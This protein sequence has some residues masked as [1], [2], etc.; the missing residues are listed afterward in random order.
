[1]LPAVDNAA[2]Y[3]ATTTF[4]V[5]DL[6]LGRLTAAD[7]V[8]DLA[9]TIPDTS[10]TTYSA[11]LIAGGSITSV[12]GGG[13]G[14]FSA[15]NETLG[16]I[17]DIYASAGLVLRDFNND[18]KEDAVMGD[19]AAG[20]SSWWNGSG[21]AGLQAQYALTSA[22]AGLFG[23][24]SPVTRGAVTGSV[25]TLGIAA[26][27]VN[28]DGAADFMVAGGFVSWGPTSGLGQWQGNNG[29]AFT[30]VT[31]TMPGTIPRYRYV[32]TFDGDFDVPLDV[33]VSAQ[34]NRID[35]FKGRT[36][37]LGLQFKQ[38]ITL[39]S[40]S[41][42]LGRIRNGDFNAD[43]RD[44]LCAAMSFFFDYRTYNFSPH[45]GSVNDR[46]NGSPTGV[47]IFLNTSN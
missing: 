17:P 35:V 20:V 43:G 9:Y 4:H 37:T 40:G 2:P 46:G 32:T 10:S 18:N 21:T 27:D 22:G 11:W 16:R 36:G 30:A 25:E 8:P 19:E 44:D 38:T 13:N 42:K 14:T 6:A 33:A 47:A 3:S 12:V 15:L 34:D 29:G 28:G 7:A 45:S 41:P 23:S 26:G 31:P 1:M 24:W 39:S 5:G